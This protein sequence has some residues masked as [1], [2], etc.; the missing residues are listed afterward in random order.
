MYREFL[1][2]CFVA[3]NRLDCGKT[4]RLP[5][6][7]RRLP[8]SRPGLTRESLLPE[9]ASRDPAKSTS[10]LRRELSCARIPHSRPR[11]WERQSRRATESPKSSQPIP[12]S[13]LPTTTL[14]RPPQ[15]PSCPEQ[16]SRKLRQ[17]AIPHMSSFPAG[18]RASARQR[19][20]HRTAQTAPA[21]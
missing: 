9:Q 3:N 12:P 13:S 14:G 18:T 21:N 2:L 17:R 7:L 6:P 19:H 16:N 15:L 4:L 11:P 5:I 8:V 20:R 1:Q 10:L